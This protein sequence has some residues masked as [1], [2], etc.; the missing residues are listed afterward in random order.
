MGM[1]KLLLMMILG[2]M[3]LSMVE[4]VPLIFHPLSS[5]T[6]ID[7]KIQGCAYK[8]PEFLNPVC[9][10][11]AAGITKDFKNNCYLRHSYCSERK[12]YAYVKEGYCWQLIKTET[13]STLHDCITKEKTWKACSNW[14]SICGTHDKQ[15]QNDS[16]FSWRFWFFQAVDGIV[17]VTIFPVGIVQ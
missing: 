15:G 12:V 4:S 13:S 8:C 6:A 1:K 3:L 7:Y 17:L 14:R 5:F 9:A 2:V 10:I 16:I 11:D